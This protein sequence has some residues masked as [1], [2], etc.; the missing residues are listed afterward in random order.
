MPVSLQSPSRQLH[1]RVGRGC[2]AAVGGEA[3][4]LCVLSLDDFR[5]TDL[6]VS[7]SELSELLA[8]VNPVPNESY[9]DAAA[10]L[11]AARESVENVIISQIQALFVDTVRTTPHSSPEERKSLARWINAECSALGLAVR[12]PNTGLP[13]TIVTAPTENPEV[14]RFRFRPFGDLGR[15]TFSSVE[16]P[17]I[18]L[19][20][21]LVRHTMRPRDR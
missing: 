17:E 15:R 20:P 5:A 18:V 13:C 3:T 21:H 6:N 14:V 8:I 19:M 16:L 2:G 9:A 11:K 12:C 4:H 1:R 7:A 10:R